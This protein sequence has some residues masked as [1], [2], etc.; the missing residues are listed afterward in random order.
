M[1][2]SHLKRINYKLLL[3]LMA[4]ILIPALYSTTRVYFLGNLPDPWAFSIAAQV[5]WLNVI[6]EVINEGLMLPLA[7]ILGQVMSKPTEY[8]KRIT[9]ALFFIV[10]IY[11]I[12]TFFVIVLAPSFIVFMQQSSKLVSTT[13]IY[14][15]LESVG[16]FISCVFNFCSLILVLKNNQAALLRLLLMKAIFTVIFDGI[17]VSQ[18]SISLKL[19]INGVAY[20][21]IFVN[22]LLC[23]ISF[24]YLRKEGLNINNLTL[25]NNVW[26][27][28]WVKIGAKSGF[29]S[30]VRNTAFIVM[31]LQL[32]NQVQQDDTFWLTNQFIWSWLLLPVLALGLLIKQD[33]ACSHEF[34]LQRLQAYM[35]LTMGII[36]TW[37][38]TMPMWS[39]FLSNIMGITDVTPVYE[40][41]VLML[42]FYMVFAFNNV[43]DSYFYGIGRTDLM[44][45]QSLMVNIIYYGCAY[46]VYH[47]GWFIPS[48][49]GIAI[50]FGL[51]IVFDAL[52]TFILYWYVIKTVEL[53][54]STSSIPN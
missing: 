30:F 39:D 41:A 22:S 27:K 11:L 35:L 44:L 17:F 47:I 40:L 24:N 50:L 48:I 13:I 20:T 19:G 36:S 51:G 46:Y 21:N 33:A 38:F 43:I 53:E 4:F 45:Y 37:L 49:D 14:I 54:L 29:A 7:F 18:L 10:L 9:T 16:I 31:V 34:T 15:R 6:Y 3:V 2:L 25:Q 8:G 12:M 1:P 32:V 23:L 52:I 26:M 5:A 28:E 42:V